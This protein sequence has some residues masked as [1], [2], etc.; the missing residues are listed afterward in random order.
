MSKR[1]KVEVFTAGCPVCEKAVKD[2]TALAGPDCDVTVYDLN[3]GCETNECQQKAK[4]YGIKSVP[5]VAIDGQLAECCT[6][7][8]VDIEVLRQLGLGKPV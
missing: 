7:G 8:G 1:R 2:V 5:A 6:G 3:K 4:T